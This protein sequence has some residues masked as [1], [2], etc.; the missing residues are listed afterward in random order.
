MKRP[1]LGTYAP[2][3]GSA[4]GIADYAVASSALLATVMD[5]QFVAMSNYTDPISFNQVLYHM[6]GG[7]DS[8]AAFRAAAE[9][10]GPV[11]LHEHVLSQF[12][13]ENHDLLDAATNQ[14]VLDA[15]T[16]ALGRPFHDPAELA[17]VM[18]RERYLQYLDLG[19]ERMV[20]DRATVVFTHSQTAL[21]TLAQRYGNDRVWPVEFPARPLPRCQRYQART[22]LRIPAAATVFG[23]FGFVGRHKR[24]PQLLAAWS[25]LHVAP[26]I[27]RLLIAGSGTS[28]L[29]PVGHPSITVLEYVK[30]GDEFRRLLSAADVG[31]QLRGP[32]LGETS[33]VIAQLLASDVPVI[34][35]TESVLPVWAN[36]ELVRIVP[37]G[38][39]EVDELANVIAGYLI[40]LPTGRGRLDDMSIPSWSESVLTA[41][42]IEVTPEP[43]GTR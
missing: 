23:S 8:V 12:F 38:P 37:P 31:V 41:L 9:R 18:E 22:D 19:L 6:G 20:F 26:D 32:S 2:L 35:S 11:I 14:V 25:S 42:G 30:S 1:T 4:S 29:R 40:S 7:R 21:T 3:P 15:F 27:G 33:G 16:S 10:P 13:V 39:R 5:V 28:R 17:H 43:A 34:T 24:L 36:Q